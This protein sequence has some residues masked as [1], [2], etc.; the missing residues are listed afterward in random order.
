M[1]QG[2][3]IS[4]AICLT[5]SSI[6]ESINENINPN[7]SKKNKCN[8]LK[9]LQTNRQDNTVKECDDGG[10]YKITQVQGTLFLIT[11]IYIERIIKNIFC[12]NCNSRCLL[13]L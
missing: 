7:L 2:S 5:Y 3:Q 8:V 12:G 11:V 4:D 6:D 13:V 9:D 10:F 1:S